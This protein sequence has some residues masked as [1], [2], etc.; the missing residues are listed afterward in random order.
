M[1][2]PHLVVDKAS[3]ILVENLSSGVPVVQGVVGGALSIGASSI[4]PVVN[5]DAHGAGLTVIGS[6]ANQLTVSMVTPTSIQGTIQAGVLQEEQVISQAYDVLL[7]SEG[8][9]PVNEGLGA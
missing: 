3:V 5:A 8:V 1:P 9:F 2:P 6:Y 4:E 7:G